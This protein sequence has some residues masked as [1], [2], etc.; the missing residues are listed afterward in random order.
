[1]SLTAEQ[2]RTAELEDAA[3]YV[4]RGDGEVVAF[5]RGDNTDLYR[6]PIADAPAVI[7]QRLA[8]R[9]A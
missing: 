3:L 4:H 5:R 9:A 6:G 7:Q 2:I 8:D 1:M